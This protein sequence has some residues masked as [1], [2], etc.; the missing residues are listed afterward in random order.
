MK[1]EKRGGSRPGAG[2]PQ[3]AKGKSNIDPE[4]KRNRLSIRLP[5]W[6]IDQVK[7]KA[8]SEGTSPGRIIERYI[9]SS[10]GFIDLKPPVTVDN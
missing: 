7:A 5:K 9:V 6:V 10:Y 1:K 8:E 4:L 3:G 2:R